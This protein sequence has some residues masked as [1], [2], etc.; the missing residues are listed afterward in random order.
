MSLAA[1]VAT[2]SL[3]GFYCSLQI[4]AHFLLAKF[5]TFRVSPPKSKK[6]MDSLGLYDKMLFLTSVLQTLNSA[7]LFPLS[8]TSQGF[9]LRFCDANSHPLQPRLFPSLFAFLIQSK[10]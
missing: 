1:T 7:F 6:C 10:G 8:F 4:T 9:R 2:T 5:C 3:F